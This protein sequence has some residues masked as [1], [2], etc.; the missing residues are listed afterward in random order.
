MTLYD[1]DGHFTKHLLL[2]FSR[3]VAEDAVSRRSSLYA[4]PRME[5]SSAFSDYKSIVLF[6]FYGHSSLNDHLS[7]F[8]LAI[9]KLRAKSTV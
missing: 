9:G 5:Y 8:T 4:D 2:H 7:L 6:C 3:N 1:T